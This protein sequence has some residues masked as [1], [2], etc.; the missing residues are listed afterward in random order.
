LRC[1]A[2]KDFNTSGVFDEMASFYPSPRSG[3]LAH[4]AG[5]LKLSVELRLHQLN[6]Q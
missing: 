5:Q 1:R 2:N 4:G 6:R 3:H